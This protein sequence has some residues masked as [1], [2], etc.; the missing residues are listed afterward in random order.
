MVDVTY[1]LSVSI[2]IDLYRSVSICIDLYLSVSIYIDLYRSVSICID[3]YRSLCP[4]WCGVA[5]AGRCAGNKRARGRTA[6]ATRTTGIAT[7]RCA[8][9]ASCLRPARTIGTALCRRADLACI[10]AVPRST[11]GEGLNSFLHLKCGLQL[12]VQIE[13]TIIVQLDCTSG[14]Y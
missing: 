9:A 7:T 8:A 11:D 12:Y 1:L 14:C 4:R 10:R 13:Y 5:S 2:C 3:L 6:P